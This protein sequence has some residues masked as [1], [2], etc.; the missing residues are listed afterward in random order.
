MRRSA[1]A[2]LVVA[3]AAAVHPSVAAQAPDA[4]S[5]AG[6]WAIDPAQ[7]Q[8]PSEVGFPIDW[9][10]PDVVDPGGRGGRG[11]GRPVTPGGIV[12]PESEDDAKRV[13][14]L[15]AE[16]RTPSTRLWIIEAPALVTMTD[17]QGRMRS[18]HPD[19]RDEIMQLAGV[20]V[21]VNARR[22]FGRL[23]VLFKVGPGREI[24]Y[25]FSRAAGAG[26]LVV[27]V[28]FLERGRGDAVRRIYGPAAPSD[29]MLVPRAAPA[30]TP[31]AGGEFAAPSR[32]DAGGGLPA[33][34]RPPEPFNQQPDAELRRLT[35]L[36]VVVEGLTPQAAACGV[37][38]D[39]IAAAVSKRLTDAGFKVVRDSDEDS[40]LYVHVMTTSISANFCVSRYDVFIYS[41]TTA[42]LSYQDK[43]VLVQVQLLHKGGL[44][45]GAP[46][47][48][49]D[50]VVKGVQDY[51]DQ[52]VTRIREA[53]K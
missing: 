1:V 46:A 2:L 3:L 26:Q 39:P 20:P 13:Q 45:G 34:G 53:N 33:A 8:F 14:Q 6:R 28:Q 18:F 24:R 30:S 17:D 23:V 51:V 37:S 25:T 16:A 42:T 38:Q 21:T 48:H 47:A 12:L 15:T 5:I 10:A 52:F 29:S 27:D 44:T 32:P 22:E 9:V 7:S 40:Y 11:G 31:A 36:G 43:P 41:H 4:A 49:G 50:G 19:G 35:S